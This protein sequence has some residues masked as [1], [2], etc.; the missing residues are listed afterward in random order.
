[1]WVAGAASRRAPPGSSSNASSCLRARRARSG[2]SGL[3]VP[4]PAPVAQAGCPAGGRHRG[5][6]GA[7]PRPAR[8]ICESMGAGA[9][10]AALVSRRV[11]RCVAIGKP[12]E[13]ERPCPPLRV[14]AL[15]QTGQVAGGAFSLAYFPSAEDALHLDF[16]DGDLTRVP[17]LCRRFSARSIRQ[18]VRPS[19]LSHRFSGPAASTSWVLVTHESTTRRRE[20]R[21]ER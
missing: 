6:Q 14:A 8:F 17:S 19:G 21:I 4:R 1:M 12:V 16:L 7:S 13:R 2:K 20:A 11:V 15:C 9:P 10:T 5:D 3:H 18:G